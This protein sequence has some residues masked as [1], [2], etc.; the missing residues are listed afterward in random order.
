LSQARQFD[1]IISGAGPAGAACVLALKNSSLKIAWVDKHVFPRDKVCGDAIPSNVQK[2][3]S[4][5]DDVLLKDFLENFPQKN[6]VEG[7]RLIAPDFSHFDLTFVRKGH[8]AKRLDFDNYLFELACAHNK[9]I[10]LFTGNA[11]ADVV[12]DPQKVN[13]TL[14]N[15]E[16]LQS[17]IIVGCDGAHS[18]VKKKLAHGINDKMDNIA[19]VRQY[20]SNVGGLE[21]NMLEIHFVK[22]FMPGYFWIFPLTNNTCNV[23]FGMVSRYI[24]KH[25]IDLK[26]SMHQIIA[27]VEPMQ[28]RFTNAITDGVVSG[29]GL[30][31]GGVRRTISGNGFLLCG[32]AA[33]LINPATGEGIGNAMISGRIAGEHILQ[34]FE[35][36]KFNAAFNTAYDSTV[37]KKLLGDLRV[38]RLL[39]KL[40]GEREWLVNFALKQVSKHE[41]I[42][43]RVRKFF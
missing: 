23:G 35:Q 32:D 18:M 10:S 14:A 33:S 17:N 36:N 28:K 1:V 19:A 16:K 30:P 2:V 37:Y 9:N 8:A 22:G 13:A 39:Q 42:R 41:F 7:C 43:E 34:C 24:S 11:L 38:Q 21:D 4:G 12:Y 27:D 40:T 15:G 31:C 20:Y 25:K 29:F 6:T 26:R 3:L 5:I